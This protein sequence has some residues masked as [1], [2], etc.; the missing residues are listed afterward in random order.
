MGMHQAI[1]RV[2]PAPGQHDLW[3]LDL[4]EYGGELPCNNVR[5]FLYYLASPTTRV[6]KVT[7][8]YVPRR[9]A[10]IRVY[11]PVCDYDGPLYIEM[12][13]T[14]AQH[15]ATDNKKNIL[16]LTAD[17]R[18]VMFAKFK[19]H[20]KTEHPDFDKPGL[21]TAKRLYEILGYPW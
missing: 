7:K 11:G 17:E 21:I 6:A 8:F 12:Y 14:A 4:L 3:E 9:S 16:T 1:E 18:H 13:I 19:K 15:S 2:A 10:D 20:V 5:T